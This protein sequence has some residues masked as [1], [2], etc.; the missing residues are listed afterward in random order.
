MKPLVFKQNNR[1][2]YTLHRDSKGKLTATASATWRWAITKA[3]ITAHACPK[4]T[5]EDCE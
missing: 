4:L 3:L 2:W 5:W 1:H